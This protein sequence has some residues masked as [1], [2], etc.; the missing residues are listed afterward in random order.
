MS[1]RNVSL[2]IIGAGPAGLSAAAQAAKLGIDTV[3][4][5]MHAQAGG[6]FFSLPPDEFQLLHPKKDIEEG[7]SIINQAK[8]AGAEILTG[9]E[10]WGI[11][12]EDPFRIC[13]SGSEPKEIRASKIILAPGAIERSYP[14]PGWTLPG[15]LTAGGALSLLKNQKI[16]PGQRVLISGTGP[17]QLALAAQL[18]SYDV[19]V[20]GVLELESRGSLLD[21]WRSMISAA[22]QYERIWEG[23]NYLLKLRSRKV[24]YLFGWSVIRALGEKEV[25]GAVIAQV[26]NTGKPMPGSEKTIE[27]DCI[28]LGYGLL[29]DT[30]FTRLLECAHILHPQLHVLVPV[31]DE[32]LQTS[33]AGVFAVGD[34]ADI[35]GKVAATL[36]GRLAAI[37]VALQSGQIDEAQACQLSKSFLPKLSI[38][39]RFAQQLLRVFNLPP[40]PC[41]LADPE[42][43]ICRCECITYQQIQ[44]AI[45]D[46]ATS[47]QAVK[48]HSRAGMGWCRGITCAPLISQIISQQGGIDLEYAS[49]ASTRPPIFPVALEDALDHEGLP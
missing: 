7:K 39:R 40:D 1:T 38:E 18:A 24:P 5:D 25:G 36:E 2:A 35:N 12:P 37:G 17:L 27:V 8:N 21:S 34:A 46:G 43:V 10:V 16:L 45:R 47:V 6:H 33:L 20:E 48:Y 11:Y 13:L 3:V 9:A 22:S 44:E 31:R 4:L 28:C 49:R 19:D 32:W 42:T 41:V 14:F 29:P 15:V 30:Q 26:G 23:L